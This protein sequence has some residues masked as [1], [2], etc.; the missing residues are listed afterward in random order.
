MR[1]CVLTTILTTFGVLIPVRALAV[2]TGSLLADGVWRSATAAAFA[3][4]GREKRDRKKPPPPD[5]KELRRLY[6]R[7]DSLI[8]Q[9]TGSGMWTQ[10]AAI[11]EQWLDAIFKSKGPQ[12]EAEY[13]FK[14]LLI[15]ATRHAPDNAGGEKS[16][17]QTI[18]QRYNLTD[19]QTKLL[20][21][22][23]RKKKDELYVREIRN[24]VPIAG[25][26]VA[27]RLS[28]KPF[29]PEQV[30][31]WMEVLRPIGEEWWGEITQELKD[32]SSEHLTPAQESRVKWDLGHIDKRVRTVFIRA[33]TWEK[34]DWTP[35]M[36]GLQN[37]PVHIPLQMKLTQER[38]A[39]LAGKAGQTE[40]GPAATTQGYSIAPHVATQPLRIGQQGRQEEPDP[41]DGSLLLPDE[42]KWVKY[43]QSFSS[44]YG[45]NKAQRAAANAV[46]KD[47]QDRATA[48]RSSRANDIDRLRK[49]LRAAGSSQRK[50]TQEELREILSGIDELFGE[51]KSRLQSIPTSEQVRDAGG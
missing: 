10:H 23:Y 24:L 44:R 34:G 25:E 35:E 36:W 45:F 26:I 18:Q 47:L 38:Q 27:T 12:S 40:L 51:L 21:K 11:I 17:F 14:Q 37:D 7:N 49:R 2:P 3:A 4:R 19:E 30:A 48:Y 39:K 28:N 29:K 33:K 46:L 15:N 20:T 50:A 31:K 22:W 42:S 1:K 32:F 16:L 8:A 13:F 9:V 43:V 41:I 6:K 5:P